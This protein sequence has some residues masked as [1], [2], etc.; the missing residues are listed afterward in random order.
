MNLCRSDCCKVASESSV[1][2]N[3][4]HLNVVEMSLWP[5]DW[6]LFLPSSWPSGHKLGFG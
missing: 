5:S 6:L 3:V 2:M 4:L 1:E